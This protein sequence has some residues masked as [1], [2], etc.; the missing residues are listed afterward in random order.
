MKNKEIAKIF[1]EISEFLKMEQETGYRIAAYEKAG[2][3]IEA[4][5]QDVGKIYSEKGKDGLRQISG[6]GEIFSNK[7]EE[8]LKKGKINLHQDYL[9]KMPVNLNELLSVEGIGPMTIKTLYSELKIKNLKDLEKAAKKGLIAPLF[10]FGEKTEK[11]ILQSIEFVK[12][13]QGRFLLAEVLPIVQEIEKSLKSLKEVDKVSVAGSVRRR[14]ETI[15]DIDFLVVSKKP[16]KVMQYF[17]SLPGVVKIWGQGSTKSSVRLQGGLDVDLRIVPAKSYG[18]A[19]QYFTGSK[20]HNIETRKIAIDL[21]L[22]L[23]EY[24]LYKGKKMIASKTEKQIYSALNMQYVE[25]E[26]RQDTGEIELALKKKLPK[27]IE[28]KDIKGDLQCHTNWSDGENTIR[29]M[30][31][32]AVSL[33]YEYLGISDHAGSLRIANGLNEKRYASQRKEIRRVDKEIKEIRILQGAEVNVLKNGSLD[34]SDSALA[35]LDY[36]LI[37]VHSNMKMEKKEMTQRIIKAMKNPLV[38][39][40]VHPTGRLIGKREEYE[41]DFEKIIRAAKEFN[42]ILE[43]N[44]SPQRLDLD[45]RKIRACKEAGVKM[46]INTDAHSVDSLEQMKYGVFQARRG[47]VGKKKIINSRKLAHYLESY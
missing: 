16:K 30:A 47:W 2:L 43:I 41:L 23:N 5:D 39:V 32:K 29:Q 25:P 12:K 22:K 27:L 45:V 11:N 36:V 20:E 33:G 8:Y 18:A 13:S 28:L 37:G 9:K 17:V 24:G 40:L 44:A 7:I 35:K 46:I 4:L 38:N 31:L 15:G 1:Y 19:L 6:I 14:K 42:V 10:G 34:I 21:G 26:L 3:A